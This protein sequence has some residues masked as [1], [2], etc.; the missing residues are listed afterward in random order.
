[1]IWFRIIREPYKAK[2]VTEGTRIGRL[3]GDYDGAWPEAKR[4]DVALIKRKE[5]QTTYNF[6]ITIIITFLT[7][8]NFQRY[9]SNVRF[10][11][12]YAYAR[13]ASDW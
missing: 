4:H 12:I 9:E 1:M 7:S 8:H 3:T 10:G 11:A 5:K 2:I 6:T 13:E